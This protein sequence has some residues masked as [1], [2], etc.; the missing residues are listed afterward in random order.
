[1]GTSG[2]FVDISFAGEVEGRQIC[3]HHIQ[4]WIWVK[5]VCCPKQK[6]STIIQSIE[7]YE[8]LKMFLGYCSQYYMLSYIYR[9][10]L[11]LIKAL[12]VL[13]EGFTI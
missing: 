10:K 6:S 7:K 1:M 13:K 4:F 2:G 12:K 5:Y 9:Q 3:M 11:E 8:I